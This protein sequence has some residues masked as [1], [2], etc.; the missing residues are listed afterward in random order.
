MALIEWSDK[1]SVGVESIDEQHKKLVNM[2]N[3]LNDALVRGEADAVLVK[4][5]D[6]LAVYTQK[7]FQYEEQ[8]FAEHGYPMAADHKAEHDAL[9]AQVVE[10]KTKLDAGS[11]MIGIELMKFLKGWLTNHILKS[12]MAYSAH[13]RGRKVA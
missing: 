5:F 9:I 12:D 6:G 13:L 11:A 4:I 8:L 10:L 2:I 1:M 7:H 3:A